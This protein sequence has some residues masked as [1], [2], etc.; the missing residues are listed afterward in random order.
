MSSKDA[1]INKKLQTLI[2]QN[3]G[4]S[5]SKRGSTLTFGGPP[6]DGA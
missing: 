4:D 6:S 2:K 3:E 5:M 1:V